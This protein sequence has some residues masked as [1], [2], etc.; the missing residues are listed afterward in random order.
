MFKMSMNTLLGRVV[1][2]LMAFVTL[3]I[4]ANV[5]VKNA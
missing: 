5:S 1:L 2:F 4:L 3:S